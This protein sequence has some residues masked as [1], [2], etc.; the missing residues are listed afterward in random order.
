MKISRRTFITGA[1][2]PL[3]VPA[4]K[5]PQLAAVVT[6]IRKFSHGQHIVDRFLEGYGWN[7]KHHHP[8]MD[9]VSLYVDQHPKD[10]LVPDR[11]ARFP[12]MK[13][14][15][16]IAEALT[17]GTGKLAVDGVVLV[18]EHGDYPR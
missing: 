11:A 13:V 8:E 4:Q 18:G 1:A 10:D 2:A 5:R 17:R 9:L 3:L 7:G 16:T 14:Y 15:P 12:Q 6:E